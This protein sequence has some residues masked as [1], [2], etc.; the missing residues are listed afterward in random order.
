MRPMTAT[1]SAVRPRA[2]APGARVALVAP[3]GPLAPERIE[4]SVARCRALGLEPVV[5]PAAGERHRFLAGTDT[6]RLGDLQA[7]FDDRAVDAVWALRGGYGTQRILDR[8]DLARQREAPIPF[9][10]FSDNTTLHVRH[11][12]MGVVSFHG[13]HPGAEFPPETEA[14]FR[15]VLFS[16]EAAGALPLRASDPEPMG[17]VGGVSEGPLY[18]GNL[19]MMA[20]LCGTSDAPAARGRVV[21]LED[22]GEPAY[23]VDRMLIQLERSGAL[24]GVV[25]LAFGRFTEGEDDEEH[26]VADVLREVA[27]R[28]GVPAA[29]DLPFGHVPHNWTLPVGVRARLDGDGAT[30]TLVEPAV[31]GA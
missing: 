24:D 7:A 5:F 23:K 31:S 10:G 6:R 4:A 21:F 16:P 12:A 2:L 19:A 17:L 9:I 15:R 13:P 30:L 1:E 11:A 3:A 14:A 22:I 27:E 25:G 29:M 28:V 8:L 18:G 20:S 26:P